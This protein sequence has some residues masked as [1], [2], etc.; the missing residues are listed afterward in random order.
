MQPMTSLTLWSIGLVWAL[1]GVAPCIGGEGGRAQGHEGGVNSVAFIDA[2]NVLATAG[3][4]GRVLLWEV[5]GGKLLGSVEAAGKSSVQLA[6]DQKGRVLVAAGEEKG[7]G[8]FDGKRFSWRSD[9]AAAAAAVRNVAVSPGGSLIA[10]LEGRRT[11]RVM[12]ARTLAERSRVVLEG[13]NYA[14][15]P[16][17]FSADDAMLAIGACEP[18][19]AWVFLHDTVSGKRV[20]TIEPTPGGRMYADGYGALS[21]SPDGRMLAMAARGRPIELWEVATGQRRATLDGERDGGACVA[22]SPDGRW[23]ASGGGAL[24]RVWSLPAGTLAAKV[25]GHQRSIRR[26]VFSPDSKLLASCG[27]QAKAEVWEVGTVVAPANQKISKLSRGD[28]EGLWADL[29][30]PAD[31]SLA[32]R[33]IGRWCASPE[34][35]VKFIDEKLGAT[36]TSGEERIAKLIARLDADSYRERE[37]AQRELEEMGESA[38]PALRKAMREEQPEEVKTR[39]AVLLTRLDSPG[40]SAEVL[41]GLRAVEVLERIGAPQ[42]REALERVAKARP[43]SAVAKSAADAVRR[44]RN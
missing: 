13:Q 27:D 4:D 11:V 36:V 37:E 8:I 9:A 12:D 16:L 6:T 41:R 34:D 7:L 26:V 19:K 29:S 1:A 32:W 23:V 14:D 42:A 20:T 21:F 31:A 10:T 17:A 30:T 22:L 33:A 18:S 43:G 15:V 40:T 2:G 3:R 39:L 35:A 5:K 25:W 28:A 44:L 38:G 24:V